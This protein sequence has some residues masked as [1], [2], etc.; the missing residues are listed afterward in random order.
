MKLLGWNK[1]KKGGLLL[2][3]EEGWW[4]PTEKVY[5]SKYGVYMYRLPGGHEGDCN[6]RGALRTW[7]REIKN[8]FHKESRDTT[9][10]HDV[11]GF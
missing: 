3:V 1:A 9:L 6:A 2:R 7:F 4:R 8:G 5:W 10:T 11:P